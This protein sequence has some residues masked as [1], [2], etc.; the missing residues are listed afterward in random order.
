MRASRLSSL[1]G[2]QI[3]EAV[4]VSF[5]LPSAGRITVDAIVRNKNLFRYGFEFDGLSEAA[6]QQIS[7]AC[8]SLPPYEGGW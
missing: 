5:E 8:E 2:C 1:G 7:K 6:R 3:G 4:E